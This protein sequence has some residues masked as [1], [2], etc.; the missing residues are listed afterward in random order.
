MRKA[1]FM[2]AGASLL[3]LAV[4]PVYAQATQ[5]PVDPATA[6]AAVTVQATDSHAAPLADKATTGEDKTKADDQVATAPADPKAQ[7]PAPAAKKPNPNGLTKNTYGQGFRF[8]T[9][10]GRFSLRIMGAVQFR[11]DFVKYD[12][13]VSGNDV[14]YSNFFM[15]RARVWFDGNAYNTK[16]TYLL[17]IQLEPASAVNLHDAW[18]NY[19]IKPMFQ[20]GAGRN[21]IGYGLEFL[22]SGFGNNMIERSI[23]SGETD[24]NAGGGF[25]KYPGGGTQSFA[26]SGEQANTGFPVGGFNLFRSQGVQ[27]SGRNGDKGQVFEYQVGLWNGR[28]TKG[29]SN[30]DDKHLVS[31]R[32]GYYPRG[33]INWLFAGDV[34]DTKT[35]QVGFIGSAYN[36]KSLHTLNAAGG[37][38][39]R[40]EA[41]DTGYN[42]AAMIRYRGF[43]TDAEFD[44]ESYSIDDAT[45][46]ATDFARQGWRIQSGYFIKPRVVE[47]VGRYAAV[48]RLKDPTVAQVVA[49]G[50]GYAKILNSSGVFT[51]AAEHEIKEMTIGLSWYLSGAAS[52]HKIMVDY[53]HLVR[54]F[55]GFVSGTTLA[56]TVPDQKDDRVRVMVQLKF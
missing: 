38:V 14:N 29:L 20:V 33:W 56:G 46:A 25:S 39:P 16:F 32:V 9:D 12:H 19:A 45:A 31:G 7:A 24:I 21:K 2:T 15:R 8:T 36:D 17:H 47:I 44:H 43:S 35:F 10:D 4:G 41:S 3:A 50:L 48:Q 1:M 13:E 28:D 54:D 53:S 52:Q 22:N 5:D 18:V 55:S 40:Y 51:N 26:T 34:A 30:P 23:L 6:R 42:V 27:V 37:A 49:S 11:Y